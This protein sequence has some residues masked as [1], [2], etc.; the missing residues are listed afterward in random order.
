[1][2]W[3]WCLD[4]TELPQSKVE[5]DIKFILR[6]V[7][8]GFLS[9][10]SQRLFP[11]KPIFKVALSTQRVLVVFEPWN[12]DRSI[13]LS[14]WIC[15]FNTLSR[16]SLSLLKVGSYTVLMRCE[17]CLVWARRL[18]AD[19]GLNQYA[20]EIVLVM[21]DGQKVQYEFCQFELCLAPCDKVKQLIL[22]PL[23]FWNERHERP[24]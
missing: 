12:N 5:V 3:Y 17:I 22:T 11:C 2:F 8:F 16:I 14:S 4:L 23:N 24:D 6:V 1:M 21:C 13:S 15:L 18:K 20:N 10:T 9:G 7:F 19:P